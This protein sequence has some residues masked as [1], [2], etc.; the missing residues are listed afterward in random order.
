MLIKRPH[1]NTTKGWTTKHW[2]ATILQAE[3]VKAIYY[4]ED[5]PIA[6]PN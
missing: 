6:S 2:K 1:T 5:R 4:V 3:S